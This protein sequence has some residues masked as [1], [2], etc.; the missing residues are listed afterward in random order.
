MKFQHLLLMIGSAQSFSIEQSRSKFISET[1]SA[2]LFGGLL[3]DPTVVIADAEEEATTTTT[4]PAPAL[5]ECKIAKAGKPT[6][7]VSTL[8]VRNLDVYSPPWTYTVSPDEAYRRIKRVVDDDPA[9][10]V[11]VDNGNDGYIKVSAT[12]GTLTDQLLK[13]GNNRAVVT[14]E[15]EFVVNAKDSVVTYRGAEAVSSE[16]NASPSVSDFGIIRN[17]LENIRKQAGCFSVMGGGITSDSFE[18]D[19]GNGP[20]SQLK[21]FYGLQSGKGFE[22]VFEDD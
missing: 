3:V 13:I 11:V 10:R 22:E 14:D 7:C 20:L 5:K 18:G 2:L 8:N 12:R 17:R 19:R 1:A 6:N 16:D 21:A 4:T 9:F 15:F